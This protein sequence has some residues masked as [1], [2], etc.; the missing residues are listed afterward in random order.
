MCSL[1]YYNPIRHDSNVVS[2]ADSGEFVGNNDCRT[3]LRHAIECL[4]DNLLCFGIQ[5]TSCFV[6]K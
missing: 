2:V 1:F 4:L 6:E 3:I 5:S